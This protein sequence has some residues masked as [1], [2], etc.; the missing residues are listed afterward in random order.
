MVALVPPAFPTPLLL[1]QLAGELGSFPGILNVVCGPTSLGPVLA[2]QPGVQ[3]VA[4][5][6]AVEVFSG[7]GV[8]WARLRAKRLLLYLKPTGFPQEGRVLRRTLAGRG[9]ELG[10][11]LGTES[12]LLLT[13]SADV[14]SAVEGVVDAI[15]SDRS[16][17]RSVCSG[18]QSPEVH[19]ISPN[20]QL[21][22]TF[23]SLGLFII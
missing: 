19:H 23:C 13:D 21:V 11:A 6:G 20:T 8:G 18:P 7:P 9:A 1:A 2:S 10:L 14:D 12:M 5:C 15:W 22:F 16:L 4:F 17:V 3:K